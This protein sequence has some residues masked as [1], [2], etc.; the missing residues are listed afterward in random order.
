MV[1]RRLALELGR[2]RLGV[3]LPRVLRARLDALVRQS[4][5]A[6]LVD[7]VVAALDRL[8]LRVRQ[9][10]PG[11]GPREVRALAVDDDAHV[12]DGLVR[13]ARR[14]EQRG[15]GPPRPLGERRRVLDDAVDEHARVVRDQHAP[16]GAP[17]PRR[18]QHHLL[19]VV[20]DGVGRALLA[21]RA[22]HALPAVLDLAV[23]GL[24]GPRRVDVH[25]REGARVAEEG[26]EPIDLHANTS[27]VRRRGGR[28]ARRAGR[29]DAGAHPGTPPGSVRSTRVATA[30][31]AGP[32]GRRRSGCR[33]E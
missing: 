12:V 30:R 1:L 31:R 26:L 16:V 6:D 27:S 3:A 11:D 14:L 24:V 29:A 15:N 19:E 33:Q 17:D 21:Q 7:D 2:H 18:P 32:G 5:G 25:R 28:A 22:P 8:R 23:P 13:R 10:S 20:E 4:A 9:V